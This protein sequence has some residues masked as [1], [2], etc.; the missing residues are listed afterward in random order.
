MKRVLFEV[1]I[2]G[3]V[4]L[5]G[6]WVTAGEKK[7]HTSKLQVVVNDAGQIVLTWNGKEEL[8]EA[9]GKDGK[10]K[11]I[12]KSTSPYVVA[13]TEDGASYR[14]EEDNCNCYSVNVV[15]YVNLQLPPGLSLIANPLYYTNNDLSF[16]M[17]NPPDGSQVYKY[18]ATQG[19]E[20]ST[21]DGISGQ[22]SNPTLQVEIGTGF[23]FRNT[24][25]T[26]LAFIFV[27]EVPQGWLTNSL[28]EGFSTKGSLV[29]A[30][31]SLS[32]HNIPGEIGDEIRTYTND[33]QGGGS[34]NISA[35]T[36]DGWTPDLNLGVG[37]GFWI[38]KQNAQDWV[39]YFTVN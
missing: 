28:P 21:F 26:S 3:V 24:S 39:R 29:P 20:V 23:F 14:L 30:S 25:Q 2:L 27:G 5:C 33:L 36:V 35:Y 34:Y 10:F 22:W 18:T 13:P 37:Q 6:N 12:H 17:P 7:Q 9:R 32:W 8:A 1:V 38:Y 15:G 31:Q 19:Y 4:G 11:R 16:W